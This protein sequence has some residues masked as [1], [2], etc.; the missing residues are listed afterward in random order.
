MKVTLT[1]NGLDSNGQPIFR[2][3]RDRKPVK[4][5]E[6]TSEETLYLY[7]IALE[8]IKSLTEK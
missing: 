2:F 8:L 4:R 3:F 5:E 6:L 7:K 1:F